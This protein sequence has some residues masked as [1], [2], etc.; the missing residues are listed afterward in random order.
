[1]PP[2]VFR[3]VGA[4]VLTILGGFFILLGGLL[5]SFLGVVFALVG[6]FSSLFF[7]GLALGLLT[8]LVG[9]LMM[10]LPRAHLAWGILA[11]LFAVA[12]LPFALGGFLLG[13]L[14]ALIGGLLAIR[15]KPGTI[16]GVIDVTGRRVP[17]PAP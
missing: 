17:P 11:V 6:V 4:G 12:S 8:M 1:V 13:F 2:P 9:V 5:V 14:L 7:V 3:P 15:W 16:A 10:V